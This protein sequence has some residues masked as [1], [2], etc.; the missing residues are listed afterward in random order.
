MIHVVNHRNYGA[1]IEYPVD[2][3]Y[4]QSCNA[5]ITICDYRGGHEREQPINCNN[6]TEAISIS[7]TLINKLIDLADVSK[8]VAE[9]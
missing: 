7:E 2:N 9:C 5:I 8:P 4:G 6:L 1:F 3:Y